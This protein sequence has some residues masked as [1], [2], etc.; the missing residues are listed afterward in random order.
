MSVTAVTSTASCRVRP[1]PISPKRLIWFRKLHDLA[2][3]R[4]RDPEAITVAIKVPVRFADGLAGASRPTLSG[5]PAQIAGDLARY[6]AAGVRHFILDF[7]TTDVSEMHATLD[8]FAKDVRP[9]VT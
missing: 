1:E 6:R 2:A 7:A 3:P 4:G 5:T 9:S 8:R